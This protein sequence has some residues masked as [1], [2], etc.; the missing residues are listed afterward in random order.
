M[1][2][3]SG[4]LRWAVLAG[5]VAVAVGVGGAFAAYPQDSVAVYTGCLNTGSSGGQINNVAISPTSPLKPC[6]ANQTLIHFS[7]GTITQVAAGPG[8]T[9]G[10]NDGYVTIGLDSKYTLPQGCTTGKIVKWDGSGWACG[11]DQTYTNGTGLDLSGNTFSINPYYRLPTFCSEGESPTPLA[12]FGGLWGCQSVVGAPQSCSSGTFATGFDLHGNLN[13]APPPAPSGPEVWVAR[14]GQDQDTPQS[15]DTNIDTLSLPAGTFLLQAQA[16]AND[17]ANS[18]NDQIEM[19]CWFD[20]RGRE[21]DNVDINDDG[22]DLLRIPFSL[23]N[24]VTLAAPTSVHL[25][26]FSLDGSDHV[27]SVVMTATAVGTVHTQ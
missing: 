1:R 15:I 7:G 12:A 23:T 6:N 5:V 27:D 3:L 14:R 21:I 17:D 10:G 8:L 4:R 11:D 2:Y 18:G 24:V 13:C 9:G 20:A 22:T 25:T 26:C 19:I 16:T